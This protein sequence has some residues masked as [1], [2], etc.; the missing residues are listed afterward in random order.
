MSSESDSATIRGLVEDWAI[1]RDAGDWDR[2][3][4]VW[5]DDGRM[6][7]TWFQGPCDDFIRVSREGFE[8]RRRG[9]GEARRTGYIHD[10]ANQYEISGQCRELDRARLAEVAHGLGIGLVAD[11]LSPHQLG[12]EIDRR[13]F[14]GG[15]SA[16]AA[17]GGQR[18]DSAFGDAGFERL[19]RVHLPFE[20][21]AGFPRNHTDGQLAYPLG[22]A[23]TE[24]QRF[25][26]LADQCHEGWALQQR[27]ERTEDG[28]ARTRDDGLGRRPLL[29][30]HDLARRQRQAL[31][32]GRSKALARADAVAELGH[33][34]SPWLWLGRGRA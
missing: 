33:S 3:R 21:V 18:I 34:G 22:K 13:V 28:F 11:A 5:H 17:A 25:A 20:L 29:V 31:G 16:R 23:P 7:A 12:N 6:M 8:R 15:K 24:T 1:W 27:H 14:L 30:G 9:T 32:G 26:G 10:P 2:F 19:W 4:T